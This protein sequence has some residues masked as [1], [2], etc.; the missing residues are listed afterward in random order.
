MW[1]RSLGV[2][3]SPRRKSSG[4]P[5]AEGLF[6]IRPLPRT[7]RIPPVR[8]LLRQRG[9]KPPRT[10]TSEEKEKQIRRDGKKGRPFRKGYGFSNIERERRY[11]RCRE[12]AVRHVRFV[13]SV[14]LN[15][16]STRKP[17][18]KRQ[19]E[20]TEKKS[21]RPRKGRRPAGGSPDREGQGTVRSDEASLHRRYSGKPE[22]EE[23]KEN[24]KRDCS[25]VRAVSGQARR[26]SPVRDTAAAGETVSPFIFHPGRI[27]GKERKWRGK[28]IQKEDRPWEEKTGQ[29]A[30]PSQVRGRLTGIWSGHRAAGPR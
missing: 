17:G 3:G 13:S 9:R 29:R 6:D 16:H 26:G 28:K 18:R 1:E 11:G 12:G 23:Q 24:T 4:S 21:A 10:G 30:S 25:P 2:L 7:V 19:K 15:R 14:L 27:R 5:K 22:R 8:R 20:N